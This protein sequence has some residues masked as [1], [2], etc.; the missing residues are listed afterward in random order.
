[1]VVAG[2][3]KQALVRQVLGAAAEFV[4]FPDARAVYSRPEAALA[5]IDAAVRRSSDDLEPGVRVYGELPI[6]RTQAEW[7]AWMTYEAIVNRAFAGR[8]VALMCGYDARLV[9]E[10]V[11]RQARRAHNVVLTDLWQISQDYEEPEAL[12]RS[13]APD[14]E[15]LPALRAL[16]IGDP[17]EVEE[18]LAAALSADAVPIERARDLVVAA[19][20]VLS[21]AERYG[22]AG[23]T[24]WVA[25]RKPAK[26]KR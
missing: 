7:D 8:P 20:E 6:C 19:R 5:T 1:M 23:A 11:V 14:F 2:G 9:P 18:R 25:R 24:Y 22:N 12:V 10:G 4:C 15:A 3:L 16:Q 17:Q 21:N 13:L 26:N